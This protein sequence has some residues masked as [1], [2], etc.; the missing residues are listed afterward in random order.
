MRRG[1]AKGTNGVAHPVKAPTSP[2]SF[3]G[4]VRESRTSRRAS[5]ISVSDASSAV[6]SPTSAD[7]PSAVTCS[8][9]RNST[10]RRERSAHSSCRSCGS[11]CCR[12]CSASSASI[13]TSALQTRPMSAPASA[14]PSIADD[15]S[16]EWTSPR[17]PTSRT[18]QRRAGRPETASR[19]PCAVAGG[20]S[21]D[22]DPSTSIRSCDGL[23]LSE[24]E[25]E[26]DVGIGRTDSPAR[27]KDSDGFRG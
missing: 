24:D 18:L 11:L 8:S 9:S 27:T 19:R 25:L 23:S 7:S 22:S 17:L 15:S 12:I 1:A 13:C 14:T 3:G 21:S 10:A 26:A 6:G 16:K 4:S 2:P 5:S 20:S